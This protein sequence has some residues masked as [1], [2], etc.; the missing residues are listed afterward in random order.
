MITIR[1]LNRNGDPQRGVNVYISADA[2]FL[3]GGGVREAD[4]DDDGEARI[5]FEPSISG[6]VVAK[7]QIV[8][9]GQL[10][11]YLTVSI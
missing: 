10:Q 4:T 2:S 11:S 3:W 7:G 8:H 1:V 6:K 9:Q 5:D